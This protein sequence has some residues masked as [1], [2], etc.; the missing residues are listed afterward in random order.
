MQ[1]T[2]ESDGDTQQE[3]PAQPSAETDDWDGP[4]KTKNLKFIHLMFVSELSHP[5]RLTFSLGCKTEIT[6]LI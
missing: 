2:T 3:K 1:E 5:P 4:G 6:V